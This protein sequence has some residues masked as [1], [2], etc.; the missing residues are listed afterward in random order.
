M[1]PHSAAEL[2]K[3]KIKKENLALLSAEEKNY[4][5]D[6]EKMLAWQ[7]DYNF[8]EWAE[9]KNWCYCERCEEYSKEQCICY[10]R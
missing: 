5:A 4:V 8:V 6:L 9:F 3:V 2:I 10:A 1:F 7:D